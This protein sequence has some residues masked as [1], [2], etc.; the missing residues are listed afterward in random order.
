MTI[1]DE[2]LEGERERENQSGKPTDSNIFTGA[3]MMDEGNLFINQRRADD[4]DD[5]DKFPFYLNLFFFWGG[6]ILFCMDF[7]NFFV[8]TFLSTFEILSWL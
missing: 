7:L 3:P 5:D 1:V 8:F 4:D 6:G 2:K